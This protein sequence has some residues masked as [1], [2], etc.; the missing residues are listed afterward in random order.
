VR[1]HVPGVRKHVPSVRN[2]SQ[3]LENKSQVLEILS[4]VL[5]NRSQALQN[6][7]LVLENVSQVLENM[8]QL[9]SVRKHVPGVRKQVA[10]QI[11][12]KSGN[13]LGDQE[14]QVRGAGGCGGDGQSLPIGGARIGLEGGR[15]HPWS[16]GG[17][18]M[19][20]QCTCVR[21]LFSNHCMSNEL[22]KIEK[23]FNFSLVFLP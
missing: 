16:V 6:M 15:G 2:K 12:P 21:T 7:S 17:G 14:S 5:K 22:P 18:I 11:S 10:G 3:V 9:A 8:A 4:Q 13:N 19:L 23:Y 20:T 1:K